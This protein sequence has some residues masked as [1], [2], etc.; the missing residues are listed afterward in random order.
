MK[1]YLLISIVLIFS[2]TLVSAAV[3]SSQTHF[4]ESAGSGHQQN[5]L[6]NGWSGE[7][8]SIQIAAHAGSG[9]VASEPL[10]IV[11]C[12]NPGGAD[13]CT[14]G[15][16]VFFATT[17]FTSPDYAFYNFIATT[18]LSSTSTYH[19]TLCRTK[20]ATGTDQITNCE[21]G[22]IS[23]SLFSVSTSSQP[24]NW[25]SSGS[26]LYS[27][28]NGNDATIDL[29]YP[30]TSSTPEFSNWVISLPF[31]V[32]SAT[33][34]GVQFGVASNTLSLENSIPYVSLL[35]GRTEIPVPLNMSLGNFTWYARAFIKESSTVLAVSSIKTFVV[36]AQYELPPNSTTSILAGPFGQSSTTYIQNAGIV[37][38]QPSSTIF[39]P[40]FG[41]NIA[42]G[43]CV[44]GQFLFAP[45]G[46]SQQY[47]NQSFENYEA[48]FPFVV[49]YS[50]RNSIGT[51]AS[52]TITSSTGDL[53]IP[54]T[55]INT[56]GG[57]TTFN[58]PIFT[59]TTFSSS[60]GS[61]VKETFFQ[62]VTFLI[63]AGLGFLIYATVI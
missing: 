35:E 41:D 16:K 47:F 19:L 26:Y 51:S 18:T 34:I 30:N 52:S 15:Q 20:V 14:T 9:V 49:F 55:A 1:K 4:V 37:C 45:S 58:I 62:Y 27:I 10:K 38:R 12:Q 28:F 43:L 50:V 60:I 25:P 5:N 54:F 46:D 59:S 53:Y 63:Y 31:S 42:Y 33:R 8:T 56:G 40:N 6:G 32:A 36:G 23:G 13:F 61:E 2:P 17:S 22:S 57:T 29:L 21:A 7:L 44:A 48:T 3:F 39:N 24:Y 11:I